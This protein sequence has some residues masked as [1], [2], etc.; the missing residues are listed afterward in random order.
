MRKVS[1]VLC[2]D[3]TVSVKQKKGWLKWW[4]G[5]RCYV[6]DS[7]T[8]KET[9]DRPGDRDEDVEVFFGSDEDR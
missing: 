5:Q 8:E 3:E 6:L 9:E 1:Y 2:D 4:W 7:V